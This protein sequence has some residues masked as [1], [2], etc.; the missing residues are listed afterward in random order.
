MHEIEN[1]G[2][3]E[4]ALSLADDNLWKLLT[5]VEETQQML[6]HGINMKKISS[7]SID[8]SDCKKGQLDEIMKIF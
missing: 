5:K 2:L 3:F 6:I 8:T 1:I 7:L 4:M